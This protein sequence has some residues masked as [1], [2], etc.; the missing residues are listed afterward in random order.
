M[1]QISEAGKGGF[2]AGNLL[3][4]STGLKG[5][6]WTVIDVNHGTGVNRANP[7]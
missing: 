1:M 2:K 7:N 4:G 6:K 3:T 5:F